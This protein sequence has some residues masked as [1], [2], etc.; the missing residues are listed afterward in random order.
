Y[1]NLTYLAGYYNILSGG[2]RAIFDVFT[3]MNVLAMFDIRKVINNIGRIKI[4]VITA[5]PQKDRK[6]A[7]KLG[8][9]WDQHRKYWHRKYTMEEFKKIK[10]T[11]PFEYIIKE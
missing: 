9:K 8:F 6:Q 3:M 5:D 2:H 11:I 1:K 4:K 10:E 7:I